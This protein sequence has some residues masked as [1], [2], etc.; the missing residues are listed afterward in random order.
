MTEVKCF[1]S[2]YVCVFFWHEKSEMQDNLSLSSSK[3]K[4]HRGALA[5]TTTAMQSCAKET[6][7]A[8]HAAE[9]RAHTGLGS[10]F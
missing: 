5:G 9:H 7:T 2:H 10:M 4:V 1:V 8:A 3:Y 6:L